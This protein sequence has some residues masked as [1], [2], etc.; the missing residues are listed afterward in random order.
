MKKGVRGYYQMLAWGE[1]LPERLTHDELSQ[2]YDN[3]F[4]TFSV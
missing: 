3:A 4:D 2:A 1:D